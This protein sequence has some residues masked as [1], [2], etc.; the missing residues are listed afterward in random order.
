MVPRALGTIMNEPETLLVVAKIPDDLRTA[1]LRDY[2]LRDYS[3]G[4][5]VAEIRI[6]VTTSM[7][8]FSAE[9]M[10]Q[11]PSLGFIACNGV[12]LERIDTVEAMRRGIRI[13]NTPGVLT[14]DVADL[15][16]A[17]MYA[18][19]RRVVAADRFVRSGRWANERMALSR[20][21]Q[22]RAVGIV[23]LGSIG[24]AVARRTQALGFKTAYTS[25]R[26][27]PDTDIPYV[28]NIETLAGQSDF[29]VLCAPGGASNR[30]IVDAKV[31]RA[32]GPEG[33]LINVAR[34]ELVDE[35]A[36]LLALESQTI[37]GAAL[38]VFARE[39]DINPRFL[40]LDNVVLQP[41]HAVLTVETRAAMIGILTRGIAQFLAESSTRRA[42]SH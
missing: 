30:N 8:G 26:R 32:L 17:L 25:P 4:Q 37:A 36:L 16:V 39:P 42:T 13:C 24:A 22:G 5:P 10:Q 15:A 19:A 20:R 14:E 6:A 12:G 38:D 3:P 28:D 40:E 31:L 18:I 35:E 33:Y 9:L 2:T 1:L 21:V 23:G 29:L 41:H 7:G 34:G 27:K 11:L